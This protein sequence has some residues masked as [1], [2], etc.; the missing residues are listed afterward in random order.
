MSTT[1][2]P[3]E[4]VEE[5]VAIEEEVQLDSKLQLAESE[6]RKRK[7]DEYVSSADYQGKLLKRIQV[8]DACFR[9]PEARKSIYDA[10]SRKDNIDEMVESCITFIEMFGFTFDPRPQAYPH[11]LSFLM[12]DYQKEAIKWL[13]QKIENGEDGLIEKSRD[14]GV[15]WIVFV[16]VPLWYWLFRDGTNILL[17]S[18]KEDLVDNKTKDSLFGMI[19]YAMMSLPKWVLPRGW[20]KE[21]HRNHLKIVNPMNWNQITGDTMNADFGR[22]S[23]KTVIL[24]DEL[25]SWDYAKDAWESAGDSTTCRIG[26]STPKGYN[27]FAMLRESGIDVLTLHWTKHP[28]KD[29]MWYEFE[30]KRRSPEEVAQELDISYNKSQTGRV[31]PEWS[32]PTVMFGNHPYNPEWPLY[33]FWD[34]GKTD[35][36]AIIWVQKNPTNSRLRIIDSYCATSKNIDFFVPLI[37]GIIGENSFLYS[38]EDLKIITAHRAYRRATHFGDPA[39]RFVN[40]VTNQT[41]FSILRDNGIVV[42]FKDS[43]KYF[44]E[45]KVAARDLILRGIEINDNARNK[46]LN[47]CMTN[48]AYPKM[49]SGGIEQVKSSDPKHDYTSHYRSAFEY[50]ALG[51]KEISRAYH[52]V[53][54]KF[55][56]RDG[57]RAIGY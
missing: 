53:Y 36:T 32:D 21:K 47:V 34:Y 29:Q 23:R 57:K 13:I 22:G 31:Y 48:A 8:N 1:D 5:D 42:N 17:G 56:K 10:I 24:F 50:G 2:M 14:M 11:H 35:D 28:L 30:K 3:V 41:V 16:Y 45:R 43:W 37:T 54:D 40:Q 46:Y 44:S 52:S 49:K 27:F 12:F 25:G 33:V 6:R 19:D 18:Y 55:A 15:S 4:L 7:W 9:Y 38:A 20:K 26:N 39:G 51:L